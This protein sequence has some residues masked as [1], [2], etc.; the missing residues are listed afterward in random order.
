[1]NTRALD[2]HDG[3]TPP[4]RGLLE[5]GQRG[6]RALPKRLPSWLFY[7]AQGSALYARICE[8]PEYYLTRCE[9][10]LMRE[11]AASIA[12]T[13]GMEVRLGEYGSGSAT[14]TRLL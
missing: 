1:M 3:R 6:L 12:D 7:D 13:L 5:I 4:A 8:Q 9:T 2:L 11:H 10:A 14:K